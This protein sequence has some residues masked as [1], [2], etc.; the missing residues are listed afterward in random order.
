MKDPVRSRFTP[1]RIAIALGFA[2]AA[3]LSMPTALAQEG[4]LALEEII[5]TARKRSENL[6]DV[7]QSVSALSHGEIEASFARDIRDLEGMSP[8]L[9]IDRIG[10]GPGVSSIS[11]RGVTHQ[12]V[13]KSFDP[14]VGVMLDGVFLGTNTGQE[15]QVFD[16]E[17]IE[18]LRG[19]QG[20]LFGRNTIGG[21]INVERTDPTGD[22]G[23]K[24]RGTYGDYDRMDL[25][26]VLYFPIMKDKLSG[27]ATYVTRQQDDGFYDNVFRNSDEPEIDYEAYG[28][29]FLATPTN[30][31]AIEY[32]Y[33]YQEDNSD[34]ASTANFSQPTDVMCLL[35]GKCA[36]GPTTPELGEKY[37]SNQNFSNDQYIEL[38]SHTV[39]VN[40]DI[41]E[42]TLVTY[43]F[44]YRDSEERTD[45]DFDSTDIDFFSTIRKQDYE[46]TSHELRVSGL[47]GDKIDYVVGGYLWDSE[48][49]LDQQLL[50][51]LTALA[52]LPEGST[53]NPRTDHDTDAWAVFFEAD[54][55]F[56]EQWKLTLGGR[57][58]EEEK[59][60]DRSSFIDF[61]GAGVVIIPEFDA[62][63]D[64]DWDEFTPKASISYTPNVDHLIYFT[65][66][67]GFR[68]GG[69]NGRGN[70]PSSIEAPYDPEFVDMYELGWKGVWL[71]NRL[72]T[73]VAV[74]YQEYDDKQED[75]VVPAPDSAQGQETVTLNA[76][77]A[78]MGGVEL[79][80]KA[81]I[82]DGWT[83]GV[84]YG[85]LDAEYDDF[86]ITTV[87]GST[88][89]L[90]N[91]DLRRAPEYTYAINSVYSLDIG[92]GV[93]SL[94]ATYRYKDDFET[95]FSNEPYGH[96][97]GHGLLDAAAS[98]AWEGWTFRVFGR[99]LTDEDAIGSALPVAGLFSFAAYRDP[100]IWGVQLSYEFGVE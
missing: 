85:Y 23:G 1:T 15:L 29:K 72:Q 20:T 62:S 41:F 77:E 88:A 100:R 87:D 50:Y 57:Y 74:F 22:W 60:M 54:Y 17:R 12:D 33:D 52:E 4:A 38:D 94:Q 96:V 9:V 25:E 21:L 24:F 69:L 43:I 11:I 86:E 45:Q 7:S 82:T 34:T 36:Q 66:A 53:S 65:Y 46:Q 44:G 13:E 67:E 28:I 35:F 97:D 5:V 63:G 14:A 49:Q 71:K 30:S 48:Y 51:F 98:Y 61:A 89:D 90:S 39:E 79:E 58:T 31:L 27:K 47:I 70:A 68:S 73:S 19:P 2:C 78:T 40:W 3:G 93:A 99:N 8:N 26:G 83:V 84:N 91:L 6:M 75:V 59:D 16:M 92:P 18:I 37:K 76:S 80:V 55:I 10:A 95:T 81:L 32:T 42:D 64:G 56:N